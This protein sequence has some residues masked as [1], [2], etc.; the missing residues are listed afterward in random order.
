M[1]RSLF[2]AA[3]ILAT[4]ETL[5]AV[6]AAEQI[7]HSLKQTQLVEASHGGAGNQ[8][9]VALIRQAEQLKQEGK[10]QVASE[11][12]SK[13]LAINE[14]NLGPE[15]PDTATSLNN[16]AMLYRSLG[17]YGE[18]ELLLRRSLAIREKALGPEHPDTATSLNNL[19]SLHRSQGRYGE[20]EPLYK[21]SLA[22]REKALGPEHTDTA[23]SL[24]NLA[25]L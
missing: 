13:V 19:A 6:R 12:W 3:I 17:R 14:T 24:N 18:A 16:L 9:T 11:L 15:H 1:K 22:I 25:V 8:E 7:G 5:P 23:T 4:M 2:A 10:L 20:A 21:R